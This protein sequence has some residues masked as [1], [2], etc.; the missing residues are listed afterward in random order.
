MQ[1]FDALDLDLIFKNH[2][3][4]LT[5]ARA[6]QDRC[7][8][9]VAAANENLGHLEEALLKSSP[10]VLAAALQKAAQ[11]KADA[12][13]PHCPA[14]G[15]KLIRR[16][17]VAL[18]VQTRCG[19][20]TLRRVRGFCANCPAWFCPADA[21]L[22]LAGGHSPFVQA[23]HALTAAH[24]PIGSAAQ[25]MARLTGLPTPPATLDRSA[26]RTGRKAQ[27]LRQQ[28]DEQTRAGQGPP[29]AGRR[30]PR[31]PNAGHPARRVQHSRARG[32][33]GARARVAHAR[34]GA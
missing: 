15:G 27:S 10:A 5:F 2:P 34:R 13:P 1:T 31:E 26:K 30:G 20:I 23:A 14:C 32:A 28:L 33:L 6:C 22:G 17:Q 8:E 25:V 29:A 12:T 11:Q 4:M 24:L 7:A 9:F 18:T 19:P 16:R 3:A 21:A